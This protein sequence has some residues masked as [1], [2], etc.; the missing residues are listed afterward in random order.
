[1][2]MPSWAI[3]LH[4]TLAPRGDREYGWQGI[5]CRLRLMVRSGSHREPFDFK[6][7]HTSKKDSCHIIFVPLSL[8]FVFS[9]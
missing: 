5:R 7:K 8:L 1:M 6:K 3:E 9:G 2:H 4:I